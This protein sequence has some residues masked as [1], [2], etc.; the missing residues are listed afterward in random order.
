MITFFEDNM[1]LTWLAA[2]LTILSILIPI[3]MRMWQKI[4]ANYA[5]QRKVWA[6][7]M[8]RGF[9]EARIKGYLIRD[10]DCLKVSVKAR[11]AFSEIMSDLCGTHNHLVKKLKRTPTDD[12]LTWAIEEQFQDWMMDHA[13]VALTLNQHGCLAIASILS[14]ELT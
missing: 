4:N 13:C 12:E 11:N 7:I 14:R 5:D 10:V 9:L 8:R 2:L 6:G 3:L 1:D